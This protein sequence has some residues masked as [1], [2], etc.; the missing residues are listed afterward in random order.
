MDLT[1]RIERRFGRRTDDRL[2]VDW[3]ALNPAVH[4]PEPVDRDYVLD[5][6]LDAVEPISDG[7]LP[8]E[9]AVHGPTGSGKSAVVTAVATALDEFLTKSQ[10]TIFTTTR[11]Q[12]GVPDIASSYVDTRRNPSEF[13]LYHH[14]LDDLRDES[15]PSRG[16][17]TDDLE[18]GIRSE[19]GT[20]EG[21]ILFADHVD[22]PGTPTRPELDAMLDP[23]DSVCVVSISQTVPG[24]TD[25]PGR[26]IEVPPYRYDLIDV[27]MRRGSRGFSER[28]DP[29]V[30]KDVA[31][32]ADGNAHDALAAL[33]GAAVIADDQDARQLTPE[34]IEAGKAAVPDDCVSI[35]RVLTLS[36]NKQEVLRTLLSVGLTADRSI[37]ELSELVADRTTL[38]RG[39]VRRYI[40]ELAQAGVLERVES[41]DRP[42][43]SGRRPSSVHPRFPT[44]VYD[45]LQQDHS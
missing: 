30:A 29:S 14:L 15:V 1:E 22:E 23:F 31:E 10:Q 8:R 45:H 34:A 18:A 13:K 27:L 19:I 35:G 11:A 16:I 40:Y 25:E 6:I 38:S 44:L 36:E 39:T 37:E 20:R 33:F 7:R 12:S 41:T 21:L 4:L 43:G 28:F 17:G 42:D 24:D 3:D 9:V 2:V 5:T 32:W 26:L